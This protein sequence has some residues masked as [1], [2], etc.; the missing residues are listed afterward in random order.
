[1]A[2]IDGDKIDKELRRKKL[3]KL[4]KNMDRIQSSFRITKRLYKEFK[5]KLVADGKSMN[6]KI[7]E[8]IS[9]YLKK[10]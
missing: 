1:M 4:M 7:E 9:E 5:Q 8:M 2:L 3:Q 6:D 10:K